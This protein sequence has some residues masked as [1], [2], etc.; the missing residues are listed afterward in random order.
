ML[1]NIFKPLYFTQR[2]AA[3]IEKLYFGSDG[4]YTA[5]THNKKYHNVQKLEP[6]IV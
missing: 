5:H 4:R 6:G 1:Y 3:K 2:S